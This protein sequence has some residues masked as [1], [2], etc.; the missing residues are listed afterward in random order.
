MAKFII[1]KE[2][3]EIRFKDNGCMFFGYCVKEV[4]NPKNC[5]CMIPS[6]YLDTLK[7]RC[8]VHD[9]RVKRNE[10]YRAEQ[11]KEESRKPKRHTPEPESTKHRTSNAAAV[12]IGIFDGLKKDPL[13]DE[14]IA[15]R[16]F[17]ITGVK[18][19]HRNISSYRCMYNQGKLK[20]QSGMPMVKA[21]RVK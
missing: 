7:R 2:T 19:T 4:P 11:V 17:S 16:L 18:P 8:E 3:E 12:Y 15:D 21:E 10:V 1:R 9:E 20:G 14:Q 13:K 5:A 6:Y